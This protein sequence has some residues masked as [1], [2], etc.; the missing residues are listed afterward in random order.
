MNTHHKTA[1]QILTKGGNSAE[2][3]ALAQ[4]QAT[5]AVSHEIRTANLLAADANG[6]ILPH[7]DWKE[8]KA[9]LRH[10]LQIP[11]GATDA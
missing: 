11:P 5:L 3:L 1:L 4:V 10:R 7:E 8:I 6:G 9:G 2:A